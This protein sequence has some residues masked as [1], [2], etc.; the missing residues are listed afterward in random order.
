M[1]VSTKPFH[2]MNY[3]LQ[4][5]LDLAHSSSIFSVIN[6][7]LTS[8]LSESR[9]VARDPLDV[10]SD[11]L[12]ERIGT[13]TIPATSGPSV[14]LGRYEEKLILLNTLREELW[15]HTPLLNPQL[16]R[17]SVLPGWLISSYHAVVTFFY[18]FYP[19]CSY[20]SVSFA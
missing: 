5:M 9:P 4:A 16:I 17:Y 14:S 15:R 18:Q 13:G 10:E 6:S 8:D 11:E 1:I 7:A 2:I 20:V 19:C 3:H 12:E